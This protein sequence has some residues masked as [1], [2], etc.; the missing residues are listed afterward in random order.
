MANPI[1]DTPAPAPADPVPAHP[2]HRKDIS[3]TRSA[4][5][6]AATS[7]SAFTH[8]EIGDGKVWTEP[9]QAMLTALKHISEAD[10]LLQWWHPSKRYQP[11]AP[12]LDEGTVKQT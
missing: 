11:G 3:D 12:V 2:H 1:P 10:K 6:A 5:Q 9:L 8:R 7:L 4:L